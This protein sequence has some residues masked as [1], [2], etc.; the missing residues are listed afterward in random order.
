[1]NNQT[2]SELIASLTGFTPGPWRYGRGAKPSDGAYDWGVGAYV[3]GGFEVVAEAFGRSSESV[4]PPSEANAALIA[5][6]PDL[7][8]IATEQAAEIERLRGALEY[9]AKPETYAPH[10]HGIAFDDRD[11]SYSAR[12]ALKGGAT[13]TPTEDKNMNVS[14]I[15]NIAGRFDISNDEAERIASTVK[16]EAEFI[17][18]RGKA[19]T[20]GPMQ[21]Q[22]RL[23]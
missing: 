18:Q 22:R 1:M 16:S 8:L 4:Y 17:S 11:L 9:Y 10:P 3:D 19:L 23:T 6:A 13:D 2:Y 7:H 14:D 20:G 5:A 15:D 21:M 12:A